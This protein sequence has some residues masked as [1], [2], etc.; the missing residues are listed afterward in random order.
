MVVDWSVL[1]VIKCTDFESKDGSPIQQTVETCLKNTYCSQ[2]GGGPIR[3]PLFPAQRG[4]RFGNLV[5][6][7][8]KIQVC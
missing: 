4:R 6:K 7:P 3:R 1:I 2:P 5:Y 8:N